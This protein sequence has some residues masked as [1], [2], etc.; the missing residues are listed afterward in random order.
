MLSSSLNLLSYVAVAAAAT[1]PVKVSSAKLDASL[2]S[3][4][5]VNMNF[6]STSPINPSARWTGGDVGQSVS[7]GDDSYLWLFGDSTSGLTRPNKTRLNFGKWPRNAVS[8]VKK[9]KVT[10]VYAQ[11]EQKCIA[12]GSACADSL[13]KPDEYDR[14]KHL[15]WMYDG[16]Y[17]KETDSLYLVGNVIQ[18]GIWPIANTLV[19]VK[20]PKQSEPHL[21]K[22]EMVQ[23]SKS[24]MTTLSRGIVKDEKYVYIFGDRM[25]WS[26]MVSRITIANFLADKW[27]GNLEYLQSSGDWLAKEPM[28]SADLQNIKELYQV[29]GESGTVYNAFLKKYVKFFPDISDTV[30]VNMFTSDKVEGP[31]T[32][33]TAFSL[34]QG[35]PFPLHFV[36]LNLSVLTLC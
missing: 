20:S 14:M 18:D 34:K 16:L 12:D 29:S 22:Y 21:W 10:A 23:M 8:L 9:G 2:A 5:P 32:S 26:G 36:S 25:V 13:F 15:Y 4:M 11:N 27:I 17:M 24:N 3:L 35:K 6:T 19:K 7:L 33:T 1:S 31:W 30:T 28:A